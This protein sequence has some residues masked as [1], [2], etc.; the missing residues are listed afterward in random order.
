MLRP[1][2]RSGR[3]PPHYGCSWTG[4]PS[5]LHLCQDCWHS[6]PSVSPWHR[7]SPPLPSAPPGH[8]RPFQLICE[9]VWGSRPAPGWAEGCPCARLG[10]QP[11]AGQAGISHL[12]AG[13]DWFPSVWGSRRGHQVG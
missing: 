11:Q 7:L 9:E 1:R 6:F 10:V 13:F 2:A 3:A 5:T 12:D 4:R 8:P